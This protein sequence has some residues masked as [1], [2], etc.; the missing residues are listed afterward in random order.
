MQATFS[1]SSGDLGWNQLRTIGHSLEEHPPTPHLQRTVENPEAFFVT[2]VA[3]YYIS[4]Q[5]AV[6]YFF[7]PS[8][9]GNKTKKTNM[10]CRAPI[11]SG[12]IMKPTNDF[13]ILCCNSRRV[14]FFPDSISYTYEQLLRGPSTENLSSRKADHTHIL[15][16]EDT[17]MRASFFMCH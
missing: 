5:L 12:S 10:P 11:Q 6:W 2:A 15:L 4:L 17:L 7:Q 3:L 9:L 1:L 8:E 13:S 16:L 14:S